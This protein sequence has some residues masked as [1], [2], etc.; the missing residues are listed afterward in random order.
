MKNKNNILILLIFL[1]F[2]A[3]N[4]QSKD[5]NIQSLR[6]RYIESC[7]LSDL[8][9]NK[10]N[11]IPNYQLWRPKVALVLSGGG[12]RG[13]SQI[14]V[15]K[16]L[17]QAGIPIDY[18][19][20]TSIGAIIG[21]L[22][23]SGYTSEEL[24]SIVRNTN[25][26][27]IFSASDKQDRNDLF[28]DQKKIMDRNLL[29]L[30]FKK[31]KLVIPEAISVGAKFNSFIEKL[32]LDAR[33]HT[34]LSFDNLKIP[35]RPIATD[36]VTGNTISLDSSNL[37][38]SIRASATV[39]LRYSPVKIGSMILVDGG[40]KANIPIVKAKDFHPD[41][42]IS[43]NTTSPL[44]DSNGLNTPWNIA[45]QVVSILM[46]PYSDKAQEESDIVIKPMIGNHKNTDFRNLDSLIL[47]GELATKNS[48]GKIKKLFKK[49]EDSIFNNLFTKQIKA[50]ISQIKN[51]IKSI[52]LDNA[53]RTN[54][55]LSDLLDKISR[56][57]KKY[58]EI[59][60][61]F[62]LSG[63]SIL[64]HI[65]SI[66]FDKI[67]SVE[68]KNLDDS[69]IVLLQDKLTLDYY[70]SYLK[71]NILEKISDD[72]LNELRINGYSYVGISDIK[73]DR[74]KKQIIYYLSKG[75]IRSININ[76]SSTNKFLVKRELTIKKG[77][78]LNAKSIIK[79]RENLNSVDFIDNI[80]FDINENP[81]NDSIDITLKATDR[82]NQSI[83]FGMRIDN[84][85]Y[86]QVGTDFIQDNLFNRGGRI[87][88]RIAGGLRNQQYYL[89]TDNTRIFNTLFTSSFSAYY[90]K[91]NRYSYEKNTFITRHKF[92]YK[93]SDGIAEERYGIKGY[94]GTQLE[95][96]GR[97]FGEIRYERQNYWSLSDKFPS[98]DYKIFSL[99]IETIFDSENMTFFP[100]EGRKIDISL[101][102]SL[103]NSPD[104][105]SFSK[106][107][108]KYL[109]HFTS[110]LHT[111]TPSIFFGFADETTPLPELYSLGGQYDFFGMREDEIRGK[112]KVLSSFQYRFKL[113]FKIFF[114]SYFLF[115]YDFGSVWE[116]FET[117]KLATLKHGI[118]IS[119]AFYTP[120]GPAR[121]S[122]GRSFYFVKNPNTV[123]WGPY[124]GY[125][126]IGT[127]L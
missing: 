28:L 79:S 92:D 85:R 100:T 114:N 123:F 48:I 105:M 3:Y 60:Y 87:A 24:D 64:V 9:K 76:V 37:A 82:G 10:D 7:N 40:L 8:Q 96:K 45:D 127:K 11:I 51:D 21:G 102:T 57:S 104:I 106:V 118:G 12:A 23:A 126:S 117:I 125:F 89:K 36:L 17:E 62:K 49:K 56:D 27:E 95:K 112:Q 46:R 58:K 42:I 34:N 111:F 74:D 124:I 80:D 38:K 121:F 86:T 107:K 54:T 31:F 44:I 65:D 113:P 110:G 115:R 122:M 78:F 25:W 120:L 6:N 71:I 93:R 30:R 16:E 39:P 33:Y 94:F 20:G 22:Y 41:I 68:I 47:F 26:D 4:L 73:Y 91:Y 83:R 35:F 70:N 19:V 29:I 97:F 84:E 72:I 88:I 75:I 67:Q 32:I 66:N 98:N 103:L 81:A 1:I 52:E 90:E 69:L 59:K 53:K 109:K 99:K 63:D 14:G 61:N 5:K 43:V 101:E 13:F 108:F 15:L 2:S 119:L 77:E 116:H 18:I 55:S 50:K